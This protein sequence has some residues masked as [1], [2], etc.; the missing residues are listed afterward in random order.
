MATN[1]RQ[2]RRGFPLRASEVFLPRLRPRRFFGGVLRAAVPVLLALFSMRTTL[3]NLN[4]FVIVSPE[5]SQRRAEL[6]FYS[7]DRC[8]P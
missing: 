4:R 3:N 6:I 2:L 7:L 5:F 8:L 1:E